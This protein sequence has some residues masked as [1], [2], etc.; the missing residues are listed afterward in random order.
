MTEA[1]I[2]AALAEMNATIQFLQQRCV[3]YSIDTIKLKAEIDELKAQIPPP[4]A[5]EVA[6]PAT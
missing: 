2:N 1:Q 3:A 4:A 5:P 6:T